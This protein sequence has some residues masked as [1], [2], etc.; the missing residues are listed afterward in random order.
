[1]KIWNSL[2]VIEKDIRKKMMIRSILQMV[3]IIMS[4][5]LNLKK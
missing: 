4:K 5:L 1:M 2:K 3:I